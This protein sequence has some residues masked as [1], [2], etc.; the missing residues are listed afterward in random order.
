MVPCWWSRHPTS[1]GCHLPD[2]FAMSYRGQATTAADCV[3]AHAEVWEVL[4]PSTYRFFSQLAQESGEAK[5]SSP[6]ALSSS[7]SSH[8]GVQ[9]QLTLIC[10]S[11]MKDRQIFPESS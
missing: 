1:Q 3:T 9:H 10:L 5:F 2:T 11:F 4:S 6:E 7:G 8:P